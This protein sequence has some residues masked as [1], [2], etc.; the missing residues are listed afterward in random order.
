MET[1]P[2]Q[3]RAAQLALFDQRVAVPQWCDL[4]QTTRD[5]LV[6]LLAQLLL[7][8]HTGSPNCAPRDQG[9]RDE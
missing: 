8:V 1:I 9:E 3:A 4:A 2:R 7:S 6:R 5:E